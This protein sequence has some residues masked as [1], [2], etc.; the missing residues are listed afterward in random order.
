MAYNQRKYNRRRLASLITRSIFIT[1]SILTVIVLLQNYQVNQQ[2]VAQEAARSKLQ[3]SS[4]VQ[5]IFNYRLQSLEIQQDSYSRNNS[6]TSAV[7]VN[8]H[9]DIDGFFNGVDQVSPSVTPDFRFITNN[10]TL[11]WDDANSPFYGIN[12]QD[13]LQI[14]RNMS[15]GTSWHLE[16]VESVMGGRYLLL[17]RTPV[18]DLDSG[19]VLGYIHIGLVLN[20]N[21][22]LV[23]AL[24]KGSNVDHILLAA[25][26]H[27]IAASTKNDDFRHL[28]WLDEYASVLKNHEY[29]VS[30]T[31]LTVNGISTYLSVYTIQNNAHIVTMMRSHYMWVLIALVCILVIALFSRH[32]L[33]QRVSKELLRL[34]NYTTVAAQKQKNSEFCGSSIEEFHQIGESFQ[35]AFQRLKEQEKLFVD[36]FNYSLSP[37]TL[38][39]SKGKLIEMNPAAER[40]FKTDSLDENG[41]NILVEKLIPQIH[42][43]A[44]GATIT[45]VTI[46]IGE[47]TYRWNLSPIVIDNEIRNII[48]QGQDVTSFVEAQRQSA[49]AREEAEESARVR[50]DFLAK[51]SHEL[52]TPLNGILGISQLLR[53]QIEDQTKLEHLDILCHSGEHL[54]AVL[55]DILD[56]SKIEQG[57]F[58]IQCSDFNLSELVTTVDKIYRP[59]C[60]EKRVE[61]DVQ[62]HLTDPFIVSSDQVR[63]NQ[64]LF[65]LVS[66]AV[67]FTS[68]GKVYVSI[69]CQEDSR[70]R[71]DKS[72]NQ[73]E[74]NIIVKDSGIGIDFARQETIFEPFVQAESTTTRE[75]GGSGLG[76]AIVK[77]LVDLLNGSIT[78]TSRP[79]YGSTFEVRIPIELKPNAKEASSFKLLSEPALLFERELQVLLVEDNHT[80]AFIA[81]A[82]CEKYGMAVHWVQDGYNA[83]DYLKRD[84]NIDLILMD[85]QL[86]QLG[87]IETTKIIRDDLGLNIPIYACTADGMQDTKRAFLAVGAD[88]VLVKPIK[89]VALNQAFVHYKQ[90]FMQDS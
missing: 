48:A 29:M 45:G 7:K 79:K 77:S 82:F 12:K 65:N 4:L 72:S 57:K 34:T 50:A 88:Y 70:Q 81:K 10:N 26:S 44:H 9:S 22:S 75:Y 90:K 6:L 69:E 39:D 56:F 35:L 17:R 2:V 60:D 11:I 16:E 20:S 31:D 61:F 53:D 62:S 54:L 87:G 37:I 51:M 83:I 67:K 66:N 8:S 89:E 19:Q 27:I 13:L 63:I 36:L 3:T 86:P 59:L 46:S 38:W 78:L 64:I 23:S 33:G 30:K 25:K 74:L 42:M 68:Q 49:L 32:W 76:L 41:F 43:C 24:L 5:Q 55:N 84:K 40:S 1:I 73:G 15:M 47:T 58:Q 85:N 18:I 71:Q 80:N 14:S 52:R 28:K 21:F